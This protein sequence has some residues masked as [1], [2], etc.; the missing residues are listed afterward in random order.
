MA[1]LRNRFLRA[2]GTA[3]IAT[4]LACSG[5]GP[6][7]HAADAPRAPSREHELKAAA[8]YNIIL[9]TDWPAAAFASPKAPLIIGV[10]GRGPVADVLETL[11][12][13]ERWQGRP[14]TIEKYT[15]VAQVKQCHV[16]F[17][18]QTEHS[19]WAALHPQFAG[20]AVL[21]VCDAENFA[22]RGGVV[23]FGIDRNKLKLTVNLAA[24]RSADLIISSKVLRLAEVVDE[25]KP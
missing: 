4:V 10:L 25:P 15:T 16:F 12:Q 21:T 14:V 24:A 20:R 22:R 1:P 5:S 17:L 3:V 6:Q 2:V 19:R 23:Q 18:G 13:N 9:F 8:L 11:I 7:I